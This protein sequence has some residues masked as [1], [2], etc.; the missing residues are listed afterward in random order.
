MLADPDM[1]VVRTSA[2]AHADVYIHRLLAS[3]LASLLAVAAHQLDP[4]P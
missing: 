4:P 2:P 1:A 3:L